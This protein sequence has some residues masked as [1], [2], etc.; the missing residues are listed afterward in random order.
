MSVQAPVAALGNRLLARLAPGIADGLR[1][2]MTTVTLRR[3]DVL[4]SRGNP[5]NHVYF[6]CGGAC[7]VVTVMRDGR[8]VE[9]AVVGSEGLI[10]LEA[11][12]GERTAIEDVVVQIASPAA[13][14]MAVP[15]FQQLL[16]EAPA[17]RELMVRY[18]MAQ[19]AAIMQS[20]GC[21]AL[22][23]VEQRLAR[24]LLATHDRVGDDTFALTQDQLAIS[25]GVRRPTVS[26][27]AA[28]LQKSGLI[29][30]RRGVVRI[31]QRQQLEEA[32][33][34]CYDVVRETFARLDVPLARERAGRDTPHSAVP[35][36]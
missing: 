26:L 15:V 18:A 2:D 20:T 13:Y 36:R 33:C 24:W 11:I 16:R 28:I 25:L 14:R 29:A 4:V 21:N 10:G 1:R 7:A 3:G 35:R 19:I 34:E 31:L 23:A 9:L 22:H 27:A 6:P 12:L 5:L 30:Y 8:M 32:A 17:F